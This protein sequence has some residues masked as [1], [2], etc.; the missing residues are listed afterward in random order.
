M[1]AQGDF[2]HGV[3]RLHLKRD[4]KDNALLARMLVK[5]GAKAI[6]RRRQDQGY[7]M[8]SMEGDSRLASQVM[9]GRT[10]QVS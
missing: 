9:L 3:E 2:L 8:Q 1:P 4:V 5:D 6:R 7:A 10:Y